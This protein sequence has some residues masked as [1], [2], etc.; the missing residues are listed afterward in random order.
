MI[1]ESQKL[2]IKKTLSSIHDL[3]KDC[4]IDLYKF[5][6]PFDKRDELLERVLLC[7]IN[8]IGFVLDILKEEE[9]EKMQGLGKYIYKSCTKREAGSFKNE[10]GEEIKYKEGYNLIVDEKQKDGAIRERKFFIDME[11]TNLINKLVNLEAYTPIMLNF[12]VRMY[13]TRTTIVPLDMQEVGNE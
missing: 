1:T 3:D 6:K 10:N 11:N 4:L 8:T 7:H 12:D 9:I 5:C 13:G 2:K